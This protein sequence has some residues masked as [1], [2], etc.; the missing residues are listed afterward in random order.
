MSSP[1][2]VAVHDKFTQ[3]TLATVDPAGG[4]ERLEQASQLQS[5]EAQAER[6][7]D[8][9]FNELTQLRSLRHANRPVPDH[10]LLHALRINDVA[11]A[12]A[13]Q[14]GEFGQVRPPLSQRALPLA[15]KRQFVVDKLSVLNDARTALHRERGSLRSSADQALGEVGRC[16]SASEHARQQTI[17]AAAEA[18]AL[19]QDNA[20]LAERVASL[21]HQA[22]GLQDTHSERLAAVQHAR[23]EHEAS[24]RLGHQR[25]QAASTALRVTLRS[26]HQA[27]LQSNQSRFAR[28]ELERTLASKNRDLSE[29]LTRGTPQEPTVEDHGAHQTQRALTAEC[30]EPQERRAHENDLQH[31]RSLAGAAGAQ[32]DIERATR[33]SLE[34]QLAEE[35]Q[36][37]ERCQ[38]DIRCMA[39]QLRELVAQHLA[40]EKHHK[41]Q[42]HYWETLAANAQCDLHGQLYDVRQR[43]MNLSQLHNVH[44]ED[45]AKSHTDLLQVMGEHSETHG[46]HDA[47]VT[48][49]HSVES[50][51]EDLRG[52]LLK[53]QT[54]TDVL[55]RQL[56]DHKHVSEAE[57]CR[58]TRACHR[59]EDELHRVQNAL[60]SSRR[61][62]M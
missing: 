13:S 7:Q 59:L 17:G 49:L 38:D 51:L 37:C 42:T 35:R 3:A 20:R 26:L 32:H 48:Q 8:G 2:R 55:S 45:L 57:C 21:E 52:A 14:A 62:V 9:L 41:A 28:E 11:R 16:S 29:V 4:S 5:W 44:C 36:R 12:V 60:A 6:A 40:D 61:Q 24:G 56:A 1:P 43:A 33:V 15:G 18:E 39:L 53:E 25:H 50:S 22:L 31:A 47:T 34:E 23:T 54:D 19:V 10:H 30:Q 27:Q 58:M 46:A